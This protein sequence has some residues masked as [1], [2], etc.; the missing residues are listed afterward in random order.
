MG[1]PVYI[2]DKTK[3]FLKF[4]ISFLI[5][6]WEEEVAII[7]KICTPK[8]FAAKMQIKFMSLNEC[9]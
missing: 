2:L 6:V 4:K 3:A 5:V 7:L 9:Y 8:S 1:H